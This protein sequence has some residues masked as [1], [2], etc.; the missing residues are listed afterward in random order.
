MLCLAYVLA[1]AYNRAHFAKSF[2]IS[3]NWGKSA[4]VPHSAWGTPSCWFLSLLF[5]SLNRKTSCATAVPLLCVAPSCCVLRLHS[6]EIMNGAFSRHIALFSWGWV[7]H[8]KLVWGALKFP[9]GK[10]QQQQR[11]QQQPVL[12]LCCSLQWSVW[13]GSDVCSAIVFSVSWQCEFLSPPAPASPLRV[14]Q[15]IKQWCAALNSQS[16]ITNKT[17]SCENTDNLR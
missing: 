15:K 4:S 12:Y 5:C 10:Q 3:I 14:W 6:S 7:C 2:Y 17:A 9:E 11:V 16:P 1:S 13:G 8:V